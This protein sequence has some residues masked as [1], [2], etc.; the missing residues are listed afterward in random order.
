MKPDIEIVNEC[1]ASLANVGD[2]VIDP[3]VGGEL[4]KASILN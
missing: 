4:I 2:T 3:P 1:R